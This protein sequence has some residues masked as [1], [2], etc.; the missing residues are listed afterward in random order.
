MPDRTYRRLGGG[1]EDN[2][3]RKFNASW[4]Y[5]GKN[6][7]DSMLPSSRE[8]LQSVHD[9]RH[10]LSG[11]WVWD[12]LVA[13]ID[14]PL[15]YTVLLEAIRSK[16]GDTGW[17]GIRHRYLRDSTLNRTLR[18]LEQ[19]ELVKRNREAEFPYHSAY[20][21]TP[22]ATELLAVMVPVAEWAESNADLLERVRQRRRAEQAG[23]G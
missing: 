8:Y 3:S 1:G 19:R 20:E 18:R 7:R 17:P 23:E 13:L 9:L 10:L 6:P 14:G 22:A 12:V 11:E 4:W 2:N 5:R 16:E 21:L 15:Q